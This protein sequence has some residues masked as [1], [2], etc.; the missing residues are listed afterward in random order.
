[1]FKK[2]LLVVAFFVTV[3]SAIGQE[4]AEKDLIGSWSLRAFKMKR[5]YFDI[6]KDS[7]RLPDDLLVGKS[8]SE[9]KEFETLFREKYLKPSTLS[10]IESTRFIF[11]EDSTVEANMGGNIRNTKYTIVKKNEDYFMNDLESEEQVLIRLDNDLLHIHINDDMLLVL[12]R[13]ED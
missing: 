5:V 2:L 12:Q 4:I 7:I 9:I 13:K 11:N 3:T 6:E 8:D 10:K 1:M